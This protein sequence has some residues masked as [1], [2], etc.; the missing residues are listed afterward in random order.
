MK[1]ITRSPP[2][3]S[4]DTV[5]PQTILPWKPDSFPLMLALTSINN[6]DLPPSAHTINLTRC[7]V[8]YSLK[9]NSSLVSDPMGKTMKHTTN[10]RDTRELADKELLAISR[11]VGKSVRA[12]TLVIT[13][14]IQENL[15]TEFTARRKQAVK[16]LKSHKSVAA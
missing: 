7:K 16:L 1:K 8:S 9:N 12:Q 10:Q 6:N 13:D 14:I 15:K 11:A 4:I 3:E 2:L 5:M